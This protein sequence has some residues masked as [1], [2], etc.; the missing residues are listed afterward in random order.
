VIS[1]KYDTTRAGTHT[2]SE[3]YETSDTRSSRMDDVH[4]IL[5]DAACFFGELIT[6]AS[7]RIE[8]MQA[9]VRKGTAAWTRSLFICAM[10]GALGILGAGALT[11]SLICGLAAMLPFSL[12]VAVACGAII[13]AL[14]Y[15]TI[16]WIAINSARRAMSTARMAP[17]ETIRE[18]KR[19]IETLFTARQK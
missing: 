6:L 9:E 1:E 19:D 8:M 18:M 10:A 7:L 11:L 16:A 5:S 3:E 17:R 15:G 4:H 2:R 14:L 13:V 12:P